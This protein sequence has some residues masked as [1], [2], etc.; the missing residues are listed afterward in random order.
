MLHNLIKI[1]PLLIRLEPVHLADRQQ[2]L[3][4][5]K[6][7]IHI[8]GVQELQRDVHVTRPFFGEVV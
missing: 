2:T 4:S 1:T 8:I 3:Q 6:Y 7:G 5:R